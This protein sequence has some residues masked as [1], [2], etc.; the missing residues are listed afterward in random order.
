MSGLSRF[1]GGFKSGYRKQQDIR[2]E[3]HPQVT[4]RAAFLVLCAVMLL[5]SGFTY[6]LMTLDD[7]TALS[8]ADKSGNKMQTAGKALYAFAIIGGGL[9][10]YL[11]RRRA[12][13]GK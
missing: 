8:L 6:W 3:T 7:A 13:A 5:L 11:R 12:Q 9:W 10:A 1:I 2:T 4:G